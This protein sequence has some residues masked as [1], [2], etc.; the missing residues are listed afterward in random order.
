MRR[1]A[2]TFVRQLK[3]GKRAGGVVLLSVMT[4]IALSAQTFTRLHNFSR[5]GGASPYGALVQATS[6]ELYG[7]TYYGGASQ[8]YT[9][10]VFKT[11]TGGALT[12]LYSFCTQTQNQNNC[13]DG[14]NPQSGLVQAANGDLYG[15]TSCF[16]NGR[17]YGT[18]FK[19]TLGGDLTTLYAFCSHSGCADGAY[20]A[21]GLAQASD[22]L[23]YGTTWGGGANG[24]GGTV[25][26]IDPSGMLT[27]LYS[28]CSQ[29]VSSTCVDGE[30]PY[31]TMVQAVDGNL[32]G[33]TYSGGANNYGT[34][35]KIT[36]SGAL[37]TVY[38]FCSH[39]GCT[40]GS[41]P[42]AG[43]AQAADGTLYGTTY[44]GGAHC[45]PDGCG[46]VFAIPR[47]GA[48]RTLY[49]FCAE[50]ACTDGAN[51]YAGLV[52]ASDGDLY[53]TTAAGGD[54]GISYGG[55]GT[56]F[57]I[58]PSGGLTHLYS[59]CAEVG[60]TDGESPIAGLVQDT[61]GNF[62][63][64]TSGGGASSD[65]TL[66]TLSLGLVPFVKTL[67]S[68][69]KSGAVI[70]ILG[71]DLTGASGVNFNG[72]P[73]AFTPASPVEIVATVPAGATGGTVTVVT[74]GGTLSSSAPFEVLSASPHS[75]SGA[76][77]VGR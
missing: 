75:S 22:G 77:G 1:I 46:T 33:T 4:A 62:Y 38:N 37:T 12:T 56:I 5:K 45:A 10:T 15:T 50:S 72:T 48:F 29:I 44:F 60:C 63:G 16:E 9:G 14:E 54:N 34:V 39:S 30:L 61:S 2:N 26:K 27:T 65:G 11:T 3:P 7:T 24:Y 23:L 31:G 43:L 51:P 52:R 57:Q 40:D 6:G 55:D 67:P 8:L 47:S 58:R 35:F 53:G 25:F 21:A 69:G 59:F 76:L 20:P 74:P 41:H 42:Y 49:S 36:P 68:S 28:F 73:A 18:I 70:Y 17:C 32:Y 13:P 64:T 71:T 19:I 66:F